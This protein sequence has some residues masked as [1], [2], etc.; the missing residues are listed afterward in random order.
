MGLSGRDGP[1]GG[2]LRI[3]RHAQQFEM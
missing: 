3:S 1:I 2:R